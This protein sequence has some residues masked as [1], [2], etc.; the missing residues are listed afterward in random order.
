VGG[1]LR[2]IR[3]IRRPKLVGQKAE[4]QKASCAS[5]KG[6]WTG[7]GLC[8]WLVVE[9]ALSPSSVLCGWRQS[10]MGL[11]VFLGG[12]EWDWVRGLGERS[13]GRAGCKGRCRKGKP[14]K[15]GHQDGSTSSQRVEPSERER[16][17]RATIINQSAQGPRL[18][19]TVQEWYRKSAMP[20]VRIPEKVLFFCT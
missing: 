2:I 5:A 14:E 12:G 11:G 18:Y 8:W 6:W 17:S 4:A 3:R 15:Y 1:G 19:R 10:V 20:V 16:Q 13:E 7:G 9:R